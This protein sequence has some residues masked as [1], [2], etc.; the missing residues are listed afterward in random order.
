MFT[1]LRKGDALTVTWTAIRDGRLWKR[2]DKTGQ[3][4]SIPLHPD[5]SKLLEASGQNDAVTIATTSRG[6]PWT[7]SG[8][9]ASFI[10]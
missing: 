4:I 10:N 8:F 5:L 7:N 2:T 9:N 6:K 3:Q 1:G